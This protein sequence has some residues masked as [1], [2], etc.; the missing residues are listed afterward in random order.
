MTC[1]A[2]AD[3]QLLDIS[4][5]EVP[6]ETPDELMPEAPDGQLCFVK[7]EDRTWVRRNGTWMPWQQPLPVA[8]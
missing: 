7:S 5:W 8:S 3:T 2:E 1:P 6:V 4:V